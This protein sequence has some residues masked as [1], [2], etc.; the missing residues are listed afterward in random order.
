MINGYIVTNE[1]YI[2]RTDL[3]INRYIVTNEAYIWRTE[4]PDVLTCFVMS[5]FNGKVNL[6]RR[7]K[8]TRQQKK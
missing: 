6:D 3:M 7:L 5:F 4:L 8:E 1:A 2:W